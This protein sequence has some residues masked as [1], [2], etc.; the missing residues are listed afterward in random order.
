M[1]A[2]VVP[3]YGAP[4]VVEIVAMA[5]PKAGPREILVR[6]RATTVN[7]GDARIRAARF[8]PGMNLLGRLMFGWSAPRRPVL[9][10]DLAGVVEAVGR[11][12]TAFT[13]GDRIVAM[14]GDRLGAHAERCVIAADHCAVKLPDELSFED[15]VTLPFG[16]TTAL[17]FLKDRTHVRPGERVLVIGASG[18]VGTA[19][20]QVARLLGARVTGV[21]SSANADRVRSIGAERVIDYRTTDLFEL[22]ERWDVV[23]DTVGE[24]TVRQ[25]RSV[26][27]PTGR[28][29]LVAAGLPQMWAAAVANLTGRQ[30]IVVGPANESA[31]HLAQL[32]A[33]LEAGVWTTVI[34]QRMPWREGVTAHR[35]VDSNR[36]VGSV[37]LTFGAAT[38]EPVPPSRANQP[39]RNRRSRW[40]RRRRSRSWAFSSRTCCR[41]RSA[42]SRSSSGRSS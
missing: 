25:C 37:V 22:E 1:N 42:S 17:T 11:D 13:V 38:A 41:T 39:P 8:P 21:C 5:E 40:R 36:K 26:T 28:V 29:G 7:S 19:C 3:R 30:R 15:A 24:A 35:R 2:L 9:G 18:A 6:V 10:V 23:I 12:V 14:T 31:D 32:V 4:E 16:G 20:I 33:W 27:T 34:D